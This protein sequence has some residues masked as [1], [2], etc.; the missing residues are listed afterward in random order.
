MTLSFDGI[1]SPRAKIAGYEALS[2]SH[3]VHGFCLF[4]RLDSGLMSPKSVVNLDP[5]PNYVLYQ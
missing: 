2:T 1:G 4:Y 3:L 5:R